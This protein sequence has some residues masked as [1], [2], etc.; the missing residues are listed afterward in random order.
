MAI[1]QISSGQLIEPAGD[2]KDELR[3]IRRLQGVSPGGSRS[4]R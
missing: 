1:V 2:D 4:G 3:I